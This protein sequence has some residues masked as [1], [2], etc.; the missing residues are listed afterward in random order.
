MASRRFLAKAFTPEA[1]DRIIAAVGP[2]APSDICRKSFASD[3]RG[4]VIGLSML[5]DVSSSS[6]R[7]ARFDALRQLSKQARDMHAALTS[8]G[9]QIIGSEI[10][11][12]FPLYEGE[13][14]LELPPLAEGQSPHDASGRY[15][16]RRQRE[17][18]L[19]PSYSGLIEGLA[20]LAMSTEARARELMNAERETGSFAALKLSRSAI[21]VFIDVSLRDTFKR[22]FGLEAKRSRNRPYEHKSRD[23]VP[24]ST[25]AYGPF[26]DF[27]EAVLREAG[28]TKSNGKPYSRETIASALKP[29]HMGES[30]TN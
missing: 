4:D 9:G 8:E 12:A 24:V 27:A 13:E 2:S 16:P 22:H 10:R 23:P 6:A 28:I 3:L 30:R 14:R 11:G 5:A 29:K 26:I 20:R 21:D 18:D 1:V 25:K 19:A 7:K 17:P 15:G